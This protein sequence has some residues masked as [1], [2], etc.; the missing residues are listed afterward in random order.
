MKRAHI[1]ALVGL[2]VSAGCS[3]DS[4]SPTATANPSTTPSSESTAAEPP[5][6]TKPEYTAAIF[7]HGAK[8]GD[9]GMVCSTDLG[10]T[11]EIKCG[12]EKSL[13]EL[14]WKFVEHRNGSDYYQFSWTLFHNGS[15]TKTEGPLIA[16]DGAS[17]TTVIDDEHYIVIRKGSLRSQTAK[18]AN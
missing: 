4:A 5:L 15:P 12:P 16:F 18:E 14:S 9:G 17:E 6:V 11:G 8:A 7:V 2:L 1:I 3:A 10:P 13:T